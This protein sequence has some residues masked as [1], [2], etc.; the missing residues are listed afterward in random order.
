MCH[1]LRSLT[2]N[3]QV[4]GEST[5]T[6]EFEG[7]AVEVRVLI[8][9]WEGHVAREKSMNEHGNYHLNNHRWVKERAGREECIII[10]HLCQ[11]AD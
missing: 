4:V 3:R 8:R 5:V 9:V 6:R 11:V 2:K 7:G 10:G 1:L